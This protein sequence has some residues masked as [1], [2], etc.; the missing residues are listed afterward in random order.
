MGLLWDSGT[1]DR[2]VV[3]ECSVCGFWSRSWFKVLLY[4]VLFAS[5]R[6]SGGA[7]ERVGWD[8]CCNGSGY[9]G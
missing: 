5:M 3:L 8:V 7:G 4:F 2:A 9:L 6:F 1:K